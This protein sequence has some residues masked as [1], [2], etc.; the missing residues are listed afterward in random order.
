MMGRGKKRCIRGI[1]SSWPAAASTFQAAV[2]FIL[3]TFCQPSPNCASLQRHVVGKSRSEEGH[4]QYSEAVLAV[5]TGAGT[6]APLA[7]S[8]GLTV[9]VAWH[10]SKSTAHKTASC[11]IPFSPGLSEGA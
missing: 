7:P 11:P 10:G 8:T 5:T 9:P 4:Q 6:D 1:T 2:V 3:P